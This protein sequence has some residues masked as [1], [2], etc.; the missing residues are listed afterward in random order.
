MAVKNSKMEQLLKE[1]QA[2]IQRLNA[3]WVYVQNL[4]ESVGLTKNTMDEFQ[5]KI[6]SRIAQ[7]EISIRDNSKG[8]WSDEKVDLLK[9]RQEKAEFHPYTCDRSSVNCQVKFNEGDG[10]LIPTNEGWVCP[11]G[12]YRQFWSH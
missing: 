2:E 8:L 11:C 9:Y 5:A 12:N 1:R 4:N 6:S 7:C 3:L 10:V